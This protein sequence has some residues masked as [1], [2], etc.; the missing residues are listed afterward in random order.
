MFII[1]DINIIK[2]DKL[3]III[4]KKIIYIYYQK[5]Y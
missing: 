5:F 4:I 1:K 2:F 3:S